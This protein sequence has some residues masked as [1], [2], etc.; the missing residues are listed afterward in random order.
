[1]LEAVNLTNS[2]KPGI[3]IKFKWINCQYV[4]LCLTQG[5]C[6]VHLN[7]VDVLITPGTYSCRTV[8]LV[9]SAGTKFLY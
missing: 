3:C 4:E 6:H 1:M 7:T 8:I 9:Q 5:T 2:F